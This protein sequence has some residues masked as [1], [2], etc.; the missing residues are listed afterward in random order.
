MHHLFLSSKTKDFEKIGCFNSLDLGRSWLLEIP[1]EDS[2][3]KSPFQIFRDFAQT[4][5]KY[6]EFPGTPQ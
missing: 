1:K 5:S 4:F 2:L 3:G 6:G